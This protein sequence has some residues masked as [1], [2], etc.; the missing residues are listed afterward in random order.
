MEPKFGGVILLVVRAADGVDALAVFLS[1]AKVKY[2]NLQVQLALHR[3][4]L[5]QNVLVFIPKLELKAERPVE[6]CIM[7]GVCSF[8]FHGKDCKAA[9]LGVFI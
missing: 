1:P 5:I 4:I 7:L 3:P 6:I 2:Q 9:C 8:F